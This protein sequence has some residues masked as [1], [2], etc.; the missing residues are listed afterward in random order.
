MKVLVVDDSKFMRNI[1]INVLK[2]NNYDV[3]GEAENGIEAV[4]LYKKVK[5]DIVTMDI[6]M[7][8]SNGLEAITKI[9]EIDSFAKILVCSAMGQKYFILDAL[10]AGAKAFVVKPFTEE[11]F[12]V[13]IDS[14]K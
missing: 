13:E 11:E 5:P 4:D 8:N 6:T 2:K 9:I 10:K 7:Q 12:L 1:I 3:V 14:L